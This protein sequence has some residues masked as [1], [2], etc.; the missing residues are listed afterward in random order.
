MRLMSTSGLLLGSV[1]LVLTGLVGCNRQDAVDAAFAPIQS[2]YGILRGREPLCSSKDWFK[3]YRIR[4]EDIATILKCDLGEFGYVGWERF[5]RCCSCGVGPVM[6]VDGERKF[7]M[8]NRMSDSDCFDMEAVF[9]N[10]DEKI[11]ILFFG[12]TYGI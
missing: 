11:L 6:E 5:N 9:V 10:V 2:K 4:D 8:W 7:I 12:R 3:A 1:V